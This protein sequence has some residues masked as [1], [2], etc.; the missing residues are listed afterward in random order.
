MERRE[1]LISA[2]VASGAFLL[3][4]AGLLALSP[5]RNSSRPWPDDWPAKHS[6]VIKDRKKAAVII[7]TELSLKHLNETTAHWGIGYGGGKLADKFI[8]SS[9]VTPEALYDSLASI[10]LRPGNNLSMD[11]NGCFV[12]GDELDVKAAWPGLEKTLNLRDIFLDSSKK[13]FKIRFG[14]YKTAAIRYKTGCLTCLESCPIGITSNAAYPQISPLKRTISPN[15]LFSGNPEVLPNKD[16]FPIA[17][18]Y[19]RISGID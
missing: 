11:S 3:N 17:V 9:P 19:S 15:S 18:I 12:S 13:G 7:Y 14:G 4:P 2:L 1:F 5:D 16:R 10:G 6:P 8:L